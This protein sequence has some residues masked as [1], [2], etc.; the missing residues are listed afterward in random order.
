VRSRILV[1]GGEREKSQRGDLSQKTTIYRRK[2]IVVISSNECRLIS[3]MRNIIFMVSVLFRRTYHGR[4]VLSNR[5]FYTVKFYKPITTVRRCTTSIAWTKAGFPAIP[6]SVVSSEGLV[7]TVTTRVTKCELKDELLSILGI[8]GRNLVSTWFKKVTPRFDRHHTTLTRRDF[9]FDL[10][11]Y[12]QFMPHRIVES[13][14]RVMLQTAETQTDNCFRYRFYNGRHSSI[15]TR[16][17]YYAIHFFSRVF[18]T[19]Q[20]Y[21]KFLYRVK[22]SGRRRQ[23]TSLPQYYYYS[24]RLKPRDHFVWYYFYCYL[25]VYYSTTN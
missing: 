3:T 16:Y 25:L 12:S 24:L 4:P 9:E 17:L 20:Y 18:S 7:T 21:Y 2:I 13:Q 10:R 15:A 8:L 6:S 14:T 5:V 11:R 22:M 1:G 23:Q 19:L